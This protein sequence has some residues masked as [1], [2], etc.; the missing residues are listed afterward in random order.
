MFRCLLKFLLYKKIVQV[1]QQLLRDVIHDHIFFSTSPFLMNVLFFRR[2]EEEK[3]DAW[4][5]FMH[6]FGLEKV[7]LNQ[8]SAKKFA[9]GNP[10]NRCIFSEGII[11]DHDSERIYCN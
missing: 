8:Q 3:I 1:F 9:T 7:H 6:F 10:L 5:G 2:R 11:H 4:Y